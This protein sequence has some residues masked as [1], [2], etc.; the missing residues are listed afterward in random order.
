MASRTVAVLLS[1][2]LTVTAARADAP[3]AS[4]V[5]NSL[6]ETLLSVMKNAD[7]LGIKGRYDKLLPSLRDAYDFEKMTQ[8][9]TG[10]SWASAPSEQRDDLVNAFTRMSA[11]T[12]A[13]RFNGY[14]GEHFETLGQRQGPRGSVLVDTQIVRTA[15]PPVAISYVMTETDGQWRIVDLLLEGKVSEMAT[16]R[17]EYNPVL[18]KGGPDELTAALNAKADTLLAE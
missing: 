8:F 4:T 1:L 17:S 13:A 3:G 16:R 11:S 7:S 18:R 2:L 12:Y 15:E 9:A 10:S 14:S 6:Q 5:V